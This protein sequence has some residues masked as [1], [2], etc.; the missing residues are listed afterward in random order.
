MN[1]FDFIYWK[2]A[3]NDEIHT[4]SN[5]QVSEI[6]LNNIS[7]TGF[8][9]FPFNKESKG[10]LFE[11]NIEKSDDIKISNLYSRVEFEG[12]NLSKN[13]FINLVKNTVNTIRKGELEKVVLARCKT[14]NLLKTFNFSDFFLKLCNNYKS[15][16][17]YC[18]KVKDEIWIGATPELLLKNNS[19]K[20][21]TFALAGTKKSIENKDFGE[22]EIA[23]QAFVKNYIF[24]ILKETSSENI[25]IE[26]SKNLNSGNLTHII[27][28]ITF[29]NN[30]PLA[31]LNQLHPTPAVCGIPYEKSYKYILENE[32]LDRSFYSGFLGTFSTEYNFDFWVNLRCAKLLGNSIKLYAGAGITAQSKAENEWEETENKM[33]VL[34]DFLLTQINQ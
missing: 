10:I 22:K 4:I 27:N 19:G 23:E 30:K 26:K 6:T 25:I 15:S 33:K 29:E 28:E 3:G 9:F 13:E 2:P 24:E 12:K 5:P 8:V 16:F 17:V 18:L 21:K 20:M 34:E 7:K 32:S 31:L 14:H 11:G 1:S